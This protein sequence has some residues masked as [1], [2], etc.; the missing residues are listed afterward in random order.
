VFP[1][2]ALGL[3]EMARQ[4][5]AAQA[6]RA[7][8]LTPDQMAALANTFKDMGSALS[9]QVATYDL[10][11]ALQNL[12]GKQAAE[13]M[14]D[15]AAQSGSLSEKTKQ[16]IGAALEQAA[17]TLP[18]DSQNP[19][20]DQL[21]KDMNS[22][23]ETLKKPP[24]G[25]G[26]QTQSSTSSQSAGSPGEPG[27]TPQGEL[28][29]LADDIR[30]ISEKLSPSGQS[31]PGGGAGLSGGAGA[32]GAPEP[33]ARLTSEGQT[34]E[35]TSQSEGPSGILSPGQASQT[36]AETVSGSMN[37]ATGLAG[38]SGYSP[39]TPFYYPW[40]WQNVV[41]AYFQNR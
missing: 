26:Q 20:L 1:N 7:P 37:A 8:G 9:K 12:D 28:K 38:G 15:L 36:G 3:E 35:L 27:Q 32:K 41:A 39:I 34:M 24:A 19:L 6:G 18:K 40:V 22:A 21:S 31:Q 16:T 4:S 30:A 14:D 2:G 10:G 17:A 29:Q 11:N 5:E 33:A 25:D 13:A 23:A